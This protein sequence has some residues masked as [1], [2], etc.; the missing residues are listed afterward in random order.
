[1]AETVADSGPDAGK[2]TVRCLD[3][4]CAG[5]AQAD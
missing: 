1:M 3:A 5:S 2:K 4:K